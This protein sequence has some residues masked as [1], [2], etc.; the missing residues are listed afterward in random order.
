MNK[1]LLSAALIAGFGVAA[2]APQAANASD[3]TV[4]FAGKVTAS[5]CTINVGTTSGGSSSTVTLP[6]VDVAS[7]S[8]AGK[9]A[10]PTPFSIYLTACTFANAGNVGVYFEPGANT[11]TDG[12]LKNTAATN[13]VEIQLLNSTQ[14]VMTLNSASGAQNGTTA[15]VTTSSTSATLNYYAQYYATAAATAGTVGSSVTYSVVYP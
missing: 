13:N 8:A 14:G 7:L 2:L 5:T 12:N 4:T 6:T 9:V 3:G 15:A 11:Q 1:T 10:A